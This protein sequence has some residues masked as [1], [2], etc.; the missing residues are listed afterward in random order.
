VLKGTRVVITVSAGKAPR[1]VPDL[2]GLTEA[3]ARARLVA[4]GLVLEVGEP[5]FSNDIPAGSVVVQDPAAA[6]ELAVGAV[7]KV[8]LSKGPDLV[9]FPDLTD[10]DGETI[11]RVLAEAGFKVGKVEGNTLLPLSY[12]SIANVLANPGDMVPRGSTVDLF[13]ETD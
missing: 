9:E 11:I 13:F 3:A 5:V 2:T 12:A 7:V 8:Q 10:L 6:V 1:A 4:L